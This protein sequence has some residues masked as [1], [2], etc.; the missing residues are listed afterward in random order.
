MTNPILDRAFGREAFGADPANYHAA[1]PPY[2][3]ATW[4]ALRERAGLGPGIDIL[5]IGAGTGLATSPLLAHEPQRFVAIEPDLRLADFLRTTI[6]NPRLQIVPKPFEDVDLPAGSF[7]LVASA[8][9]FHWLDAMPALRR[10]HEWLRPGGAVALWWNVFG[11][12]SRPDPFHDA[13][14]HLFAGQQLNY[15]AGANDRP[16]YALDIEARLSE[17]TEAGFVSDPPELI[18]WTLR[19]DAPGVR[20]LYASYSNVAAL[21]PA[22]QTKLLDALAD[23][24]SRQFANRVERNMTTAIYT[25]RRGSIR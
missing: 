2:P 13:T 12:N 24:A 23:I 4:Q 14:T 19:L 1:R 5:E 25:A 22:E 15:M 8:T 17:L 9:A 7:D 6:H 3:E 18:R 20:S 10:I 11:D 16:P 21:S